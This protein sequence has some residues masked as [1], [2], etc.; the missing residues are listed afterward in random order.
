MA[1]RSRI[2]CRPATVAA[3]HLMMKTSAA[4]FLLYSNFTGKQRQFISQDDLGWSGH[5][6]AR[7][8]QLKT[9]SGQSVGTLGFFEAQNQPAEISSLLRSAALWLKRNGCDVVIGPLDG[10]TWHSYRF[11]LGPTND[12]PFLS[13]PDSLQQA[14][15]SRAPG[16]PSAG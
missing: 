13:E 10:D 12:P 6:L 7:H 5:V 1:G 2:P 8:G 15:H 9:E 4:L 11:N 3:S 16:P 14:I